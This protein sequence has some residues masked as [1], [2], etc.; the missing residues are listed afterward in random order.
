[1]T[2]VPNAWSSYPDERG[3]FGEYGGRF[4]AE[5]G[6]RFG[7]NLHAMGRSEHFLLISLRLSSI[8][9]LCSRRVA[10]LSYTKSDRGIVDKILRG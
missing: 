8:S 1:M 4:V 7:P 9:S 5:R 6:G 10:A 2:T 3:M